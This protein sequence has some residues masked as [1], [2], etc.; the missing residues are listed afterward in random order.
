MFREIKKYFAFIN[1][2]AIVLLPIM[3]NGQDIGELVDGMKVFSP[4]MKMKQNHI[5]SVIRVDVTGKGRDTLNIWRYDKAGFLMSSADFYKALN[6]YYVY[7]IERYTNDSIRVSYKAL[8]KNIAI[9]SFDVIIKENGN[10]FIAYKH[11]KDR[12]LFFEEYRSPRDLPVTPVLPW[13][14]Y[15]S[16]YGKTVDSLRTIFHDTAILTIIERNN[17][18]QYITVLK[19][20]KNRYISNQTR[21]YQNNQLGYWSIYSE[22]FDSK[23]RLIGVKS[24]SATTND[25]TVYL[26]DDKNGTK[27]EVKYHLNSNIVR[28]SI[29]YGSGNIILEIYKLIFAVKERETYVKYHYSKKRL[30]LKETSIENGTVNN[31]VEYVYQYYK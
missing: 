10:R 19:N 4:D 31:M 15:A 20:F 21:E 26:Y 9:D 24:E 3:A 7:A 11:E 14:Y 12:A 27:K 13:D 30:R 22:V 2:I 8:S 25:R 18:S 1:L 17:D 5:S 28:Q 29:T 16:K 23:K 6:K